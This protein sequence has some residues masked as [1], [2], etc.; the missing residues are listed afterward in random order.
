MTAQ[1][2]IRCAEHWNEV[3]TASGEV[4]NYDEVEDCESFLPRVVNAMKN[5]LER[6]APAGEVLC[7]I[8]VWHYTDECTSSLH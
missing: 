3:P 7:V 4:Y 2:L 5:I 8:F 1:I 6:S